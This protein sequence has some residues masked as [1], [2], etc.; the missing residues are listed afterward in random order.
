MLAVVA[1]K[2]KRVRGVTI[3]ANAT[4]TGTVVDGSAVAVPGGT[5]QLI[6]GSTVVASATPNGSGVYTFSSVTPGSYSLKYHPP[7]AYSLGASESDT[8]AITPTAGN[9]TTQN[10]VVQASLYSDDFQAYTLSSQLQGT[11]SPITA[12]HFFYHGGDTS[13]QIAAYA[14]SGGAH[15]GAIELDPTGGPASS[16]AMKYTYTGNPGGATSGDPN[17]VYLGPRITPTPASMDKLAIRWT[18]NCSAAFT[19]AV[20]GATGSSREYKFFLVQTGPNGGSGLPQIGVY[21][22][23]SDASGYA[24]TMDVTDRGSNNINTNHA[25]L[26]NLPS[27]WRNA[28]HTW[29]I[30]AYYNGSNWT[31]ELWCDGVKIITLTGA[32][33]GST[34]NG[35]GSIIFPNIGEQL[36]SGPP[37]DQYRWFREFAIY[38]SRPSLLSF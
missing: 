2:F 17:T 25:I 29:V 22:E 4:V 26:Y 21:L 30:Y 24:L 10:F 1:G 27:N 36:N 8:Y 14:V 28:W 23:G 19:N 18:D 12:G 9:T 31:F 20:A 3:A 7:L 6:S 15:V 38:R 35:T 34:I 32:W 16:K 37:A 13:Y 11:P 5:V 33:L